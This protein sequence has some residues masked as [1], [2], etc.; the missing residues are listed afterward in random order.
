MQILKLGFHILRA[1]NYP[2]SDHASPEDIRLWCL[3]F[4]SHLRIR[5]HQQGCLPDLSKGPYLIVSNHVSWLDPLAICAMLPASFVSK[6]EVGRIPVLGTLAR[7]GG[8]LFL[9]RSS[10]RSLG[11]VSHK[12]EGMI[13]AGRSVAFFPEGKTTFGSELLP[14]APALFEPACRSRIPI[15]PVAI[16]YMRKDRTERSIAA[17]FVDDQGFLDSFLNVLGEEGLEVCL[18]WAAPVLSDR[19]SR[20]EL[21]IR[22]EANIKEMLGYGDNGHNV[23][24]EGM[25]SFG[26]SPKAGAL[27]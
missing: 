26:N 4:F 7:R 21:A 12:M 27:P 14:F 1:L 18:G 16:Q 3:E 6:V 15:L 25:R 11:T 8:T 24:I 17:A 13:K 2:L 20:R 10:F 9:D 23:V 5:I 19:E 22:S